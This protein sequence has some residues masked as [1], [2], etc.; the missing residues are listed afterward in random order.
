[1]SHPVGYPSAGA[2]VTIPA[3]QHYELISEVA[4]LTA[5][6][7]AV[8]GERDGLYQQIEAMQEEMNGMAN[9]IREL[10]SRPRAKIGFG[11]E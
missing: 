2:E 4:R 5:V 11:Q 9:Y 8:E 1:M 3:R 6:L 10:K 7:T